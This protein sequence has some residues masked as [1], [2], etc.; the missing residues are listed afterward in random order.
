MV[1]NWQLEGARCLWRLHRGADALQ[2]LSSHFPTPDQEAQRLS[3]L[4]QV[5]AQQS[6]TLGITQDLAQLELS[7]ASSP[8]YA[9]ALS[10]AGIFY[11]RQLN[12]Q[13]A[14]RNYRRLF[15][16]FPKHEHLR[17]DGW[18]LA[19]C[20]YLLGDAKTSEEIR[21]YLLWFPDSARA[22]AALYW[23][24][25][26]QEDQ[27]ALAE[28]RAIYAL[29]GKRFVH[30]YYA[31]QA[32]TRL[33]AMRDKPAGLAGPS[34]ST[35][36][37]LAAELVQVMTPPVISPA[38]PCLAAA[39]SDAARPALILQAFGLTDVEEDF[40]RGAL[41]VD[42]PAPELRLLLSERYAAQNNT[43]GALIS[44]LRAAP[45]YAQVEFSDLPKEVW[46]L[47]YPQA[48]WK[49]IQRQ[50]R[51]NHLDPYLVMGLV[52]QESAFNRRALSSANA[53][54]LMQLLPE[55]AA[56]STRRSRTRSAA[57]RLSDPNYN[58]RSGCAYL[59]GLMKEFDGRP[60]LAVAAYNAG[61]FRVKDWTKKY[62]F[63]EP[64]MFL[65]SVPIPATRTYVE[66]VLRDAEIYRALMSG[67]PHF[68]ECALV[69]PSASP[70]TAGVTHT[71]GPQ[72]G[73]LS[74]HIPGH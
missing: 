32:A 19:W 69:K 33:T 34:D 35:A 55:T 67:S 50:A 66:L 45:E 63:R 29:L 44:A 54:G 14:A 22:A 12:W 7:Y 13:E 36:A 57:R 53:H 40:L 18:R 4:V 74:Q 9:D 17:D 26:M 48:Y 41:S 58:V 11:Y 42:H 62:T 68:A 46:T 39:P 64:G 37:P 49:L 70:R 3:L 31:M 2:S 51:L 71:H 15:E 23:L 24:G 27:G 25:R 47:L 8:A 56:H 73:T 43:A 61:D 20:D 10:A 59:A 5:N 65:E 16:L 52:R 21:Q 30:S 60:E 28:A 38:L 1:P 72:T 6:D